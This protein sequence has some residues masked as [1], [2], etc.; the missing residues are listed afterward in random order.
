MKMEAAGVFDVTRV[1]GN[2][3]QKSAL[4]VVTV[5][6]LSRLRRYVCVDDLNRSIHWVPVNYRM[7]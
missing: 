5:T 3:Y 1:Y 6:V 4:F 2:K 7:L